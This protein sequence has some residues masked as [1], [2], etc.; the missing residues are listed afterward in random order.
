ML[1]QGLQ[2]HLGSVLF[3]IVDVLAVI[4]VASSNVLAL[5]GDGAGPGSAASCKPEIKTVSYPL[6]NARRLK[7]GV[8][9][10]RAGGIFHSRFLQDSTP[11]CNADTR[12][13][14]NTQC[15]KT[16]CRCVCVSAYGKEEDR[17]K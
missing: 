9:T 1:V 15:T 10:M 4:P 6:S 5:D 3:G 2:G 7:V 11:S 16:E 14:R 17:R 13:T 8:Q 12:D